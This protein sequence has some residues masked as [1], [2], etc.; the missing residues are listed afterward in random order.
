METIHY[1]TSTS[2]RHYRISVGSRR[3]GP[4]LGLGSLSTQSLRLRVF[5]PTNT[6]RVP[7]ISRGASASL[8]ACA[9]LG[10]RKNDRGPTRAILAVDIVG[11][12]RLMGVD[13]AGAA[14]PTRMRARW[15]RRRPT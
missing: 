3:R 2:R 15:T 8:M 14:R 1:L 9:K 13:E 10:C 4:L 6:A 5:A 11:H 7:H 12:S